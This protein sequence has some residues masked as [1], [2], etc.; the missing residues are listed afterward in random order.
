MF[1]EMKKPLGE[2]LALYPPR[3]MARVDW[4]RRCAIRQFLFH[5]CSWE[6]Q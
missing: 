5:I 1:D 6:Y 4:S 2:N 3:G